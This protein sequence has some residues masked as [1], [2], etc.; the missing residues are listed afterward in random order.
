[1]AAG[2]AGDR[3]CEGH[4]LARIAALEA[5][6]DRVKGMVKMLVALGRLASPAERLEVEKCKGRMERELD[7]S[8][9]KA[10]EKAKVEAAVKVANK[11]VKKR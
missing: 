11:P 10:G 9:A 4:C 5:T 8:I 6:L 2:S 1:M 3:M 7:V